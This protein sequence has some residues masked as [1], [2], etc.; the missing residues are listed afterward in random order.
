MQVISWVQ[1]NGDNKYAPTIL[2]VMCTAYVR[3]HVKNPL[4]R[5]LAR[6]EQ[7]ACKKHN[8]KEYTFVSESNR[9]S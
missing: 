5:V 6:L 3:A 7:L 9:L 4:K 1:Q 8:C 2:R